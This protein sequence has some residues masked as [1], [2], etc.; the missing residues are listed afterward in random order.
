M[1]R[2]RK[3][4]PS[5][6]RSS[7]SRSGMGAIGG[8]MNEIIGVTVGTAIGRIVSTKLLPALNPT[9][10][11]AGV[12]GIGA[13]LMPKLMKGSFGTAIGSGMIAAGSLG[14][15]QGTG[16]LGAIDSAIDGIG[17]SDV[18]AI[19]NIGNYDYEDMMSGTDEIDAD[20]ELG[21]MDEDF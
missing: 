21:A 14:I 11:S 2:R 5:R 6:R 12:I 10:K 1:A 9:L 16:V 3:K 8:V 17:F 4:Q 18:G 15:L 19:Q 13:F 7:R 20:T